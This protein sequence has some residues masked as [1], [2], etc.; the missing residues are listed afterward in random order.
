MTRAASAGWFILGA[1]ARTAE[2]ASVSDRMGWSS[3]RAQR[4]PTDLQPDPVQ[5]AWTTSAVLLDGARV[6][7]SYKFGPVFH[8][9]DLNVTVMSLNGKVDIG[10]VSCSDLLPDLWE[11]ADGLPVALKELLDMAG[12]IERCTGHRAAPKPHKRSS[13]W[14]T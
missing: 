7:A 10:L 11:L 14:A 13:D 1:P 3:V 6:K 8:G 12:R 2:I 5:C 4:P 9:A